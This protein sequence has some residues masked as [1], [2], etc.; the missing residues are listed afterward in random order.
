MAKLE[1]HN[2][3]SVGKGRDVIR[4]M[5]TRVLIVLGIVP[6]KQGGGHANIF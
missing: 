3:L 5:Y 4:V 6:H 2:Y 1:E